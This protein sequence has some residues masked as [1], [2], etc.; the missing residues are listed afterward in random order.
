MLLLS[1]LN[2]IFSQN[3]LEDG[4]AG[5]PEAEFGGEAGGWDGEAGQ[6]EEFLHL[7]HLHQVNMDPHVQLQQGQRLPDLWTED[8]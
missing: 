1:K 6:E 4:R 7:H 2:L 3:L 5:E 8:N